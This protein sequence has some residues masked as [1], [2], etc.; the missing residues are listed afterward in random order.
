MLILILPLSYKVSLCFLTLLRKSTIEVRNQN[1]TLKWLHVWTAA[2]SVISTLTGNPCP[3]SVKTV[4]AVTTLSQSNT[5]HLHSHWHQAESKCPLM[6]TAKSTSNLGTLK[7]TKP[8]CLWHDSSIIKVFSSS[9]INYYESLIR[10]MNQ[11]KLFI[12]NLPWTREMLH[13]NA[14]I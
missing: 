1:V 3:Q 4:K 5:S 6:V 7:I 11:N 8:L 13:K 2:F 10:T 12:I 9:C 14:R